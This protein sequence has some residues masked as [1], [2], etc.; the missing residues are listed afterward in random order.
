MGSGP[1]EIGFEA[2]NGMYYTYICNYK[3]SKFI[4]NIKKITNLLNNYKYLPRVIQYCYVN[5]NKSEGSAVAA[6]L[7][8]TGGSF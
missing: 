5:S 3:K 2:F 4:K 8:V 7:I 6:I 1:E